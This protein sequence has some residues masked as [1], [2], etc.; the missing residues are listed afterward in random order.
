MEPKIKLYTIITHKVD[1]NGLPFTGKW[2]GHYWFNGVLLGVFG[3]REA[4]K[5]R[6]LLGGEK[7]HFKDVPYSE[8]KAF[9]NDYFNAEHKE[10]TH[11]QKMKE[12]A[13]HNFNFSEVTGGKRN[14]EA[15]DRAYKIFKN[16]EV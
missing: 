9:A 2:K 11:Q 10:V 8:I 5:M 16:Q 13:E 6:L 12:M 1:E 7:V 15:I 3:D 14:K 4:T